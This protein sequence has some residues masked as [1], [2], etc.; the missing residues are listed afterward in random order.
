MSRR[1]V[2]KRTVGISLSALLLASGLAAAGT[3][4][5]A[6]A[7]PA[8][9]AGLV[10]AMQSDLGLTESQALTRL[11]QEAQAGELAPTAER[12]AGDAYAGSWFDAESGLLTVAVTGAEE[13]AKVEA[14]GA[15]TEIVRYS[16]SQL[17]AAQSEIDARADDAPAGVAGWGVDVHTNRVVVSVVEGELGTPEV[18][19]FLADARAAG[20]VTVREDATERPSTFAAGTVGGDRY[21]T[22]NAGCSI[23]FSVHGGFVTAGHCG[24]QGQA[25]RGWDNTHIGHFQGSSFPG[26]DRRAPPVPA[27]C[28]RDPGSSGTDWSGQC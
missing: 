3:A 2:T 23:G 13:A 4:G 26:D 5:T 20:P 7:A 16:A 1:R 6:A 21:W 19:E 8:A 18:Q 17:D 24:G 22:D 15:A 25:V 9:S 10:A 12:A 11:A 27:K 28:A 14:T